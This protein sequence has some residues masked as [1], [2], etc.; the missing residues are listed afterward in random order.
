M[1]FSSH[2]SRAIFRV[3]YHLYRSQVLFLHEE[4]LNT[5]LVNTKR[6]KDLICGYSVSVG[7]TLLPTRLLTLSHKPRQRTIFLRK[8]TFLRS[9]LTWLCQGV[10]PLPK[11]RSDVE[12]P[13]GCL[14]YCSRQ[15]YV[16]RCSLTS[17]LDNIRL[18]YD[19]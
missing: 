16:L 13:C 6:H 19:S 17:C 9:K 12:I 1:K 15:F 5:R 18:Y 8:L 10:V 2:I 7:L 3:L 14:H 4:K 11:A